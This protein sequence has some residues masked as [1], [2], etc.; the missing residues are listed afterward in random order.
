MGAHS[1]NEDLY[2]A[3]DDLIGRNI[4]A[5]RGDKPAFI[6]VNGA[7]TYGELDAAV[8][9]FANLLKSRGV[10]MEER[11]LLCLL[12]T[13]DWPICFLGAIR[14]GA[15]PI[16]VN[17][18]LTNDDYDFMLED[19]RARMLVV[20]EPLLP[21]FSD[22]L[23]GHAF[24]DNVVVS[25]ADGQGHE[26]LSDLLAGQPDTFQ[27]APTRRGDMCF[28]LYTS[29]TTGKPK[30]AVHLQTNLIETANLYAIPTLKISAD[31]VCFSAA[32]LFFA[33]GLG[34]GLTFPMSVGATT[35]LL[36]GPPDPKSVCDIIRDQK[37][38][39]FYGVPTLYGML[40]ASGDLPGPGEHAMRIATSAGEALPADLLRR[41]KEAT[42]VDILD[43]LGSTE[44]L[45][46]FLSNRL[47]EI[48]P[49]ASGR[50][51]DGYEL[52]L[53]DDDGNV[54][55]GADEMGMLEVSGPSS[56]VMYWNQRDKSRETFQGPW[57]RTGDKYTRDADGIYT[58]A[59]RTDD[60]LK[61]GGIYVSPVEVESAVVRHEKVLEV[62][63]V[64][65]ADADGLIKPKAFVVPRDGIEPNDAL[66]DEIKAFVK[67]ELAA[68]KYPRWVEFR[69]EL[70]KT[71]TGKIQRFKLREG[72][73]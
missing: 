37:P 25:G 57:T 19:S 24:L 64:G 72:D 69:D 5:G 29:G 18:R 34:N 49:G 39:I 47:G 12:D 28:W 4:D 38:T 63:V 21:A 30:G 65:H 46:I 40:L 17:T 56:A 9:R 35:I 23:D 2:N 52:R 66:A 8:N 73:A 11:V 44:M 70:P 27:T 61:V 42:G 32:K 67:S 20:S 45:H 3:A 31:D 59:G 22:H 60:M 55:H 10:R 58:H 53:V 48:K 26:L 54:L 71:A 7:H 41:F 1:T 36:A 62:A 43:G 50:P 13:V 15:I 14:A 51:V 68:Y 33:Y 6:D 16:P